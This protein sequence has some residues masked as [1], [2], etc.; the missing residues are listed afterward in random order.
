MTHMKVAEPLVS[1]T[2][3][4]FNHG[5][6]IRQAIQ[7]VLEQTHHDLE[8]V[9]VNDG[10]TDNTA[11]VLNRI[12][13]PRVRI[14]H[15][16]NMGPSMAANRALSECRGKYVA[17]MAGDDLLPPNRIDRQ[18]GEYLKGGS[19]ILFA[20]AEFIDDEGNPSNTDRYH[21]NLTPAM[22]R[23]AVLRRL[24][25]GRAP[26][27]ILTL[28]TEA[29]I[30]KGLGQYCDPALYQMQDSELLIRLA[31][32]YEFCYLNEKLYRFR[33]RRG[34][35]NLSGWDPFK[36]IR[37]RNEFYLLMRNFFDDIPADLF[38]EMFADLVRNP[39]FTTPLEYKCEQ[40]FVWLKSPNASL[41]LFG[42][43]QLYD[44]L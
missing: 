21:T 22:G 10:S 28:F 19:R 31:K 20:Q 12:A 4:A 42:V 16:A 30:L 34:D 29:S 26:A 5:K 11:E 15:Q 36:L 2:I 23:A 32:K 44:L 43:E 41:R 24:F 38:K 13:D 25:E 35:L 6:Y 39:A 17:I 3:L 18:L 8:V 1:V 7:S 27:F 37:T 40:A 9:V 14:F 33:L